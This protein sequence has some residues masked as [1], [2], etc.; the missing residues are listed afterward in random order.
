M[1]GHINLNTS[2]VKVNQVLISIRLL[3]KDYLNT[4]HVKVNRML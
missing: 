4:S 2:H 3:L 1:L